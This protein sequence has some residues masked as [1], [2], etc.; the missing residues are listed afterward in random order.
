M[1]I[2]AFPRGRSFAFVA[3][4]LCL[5]T[6][7]AAAEDTT[8]V[9]ENATGIGIVEI[10]AIPSH[11]TDGPGRP[12]PQSIVPAGASARFTIA[13]GFCAY[14]LWFVFGDGHRFHDTMDFCEFGTYVVK[15]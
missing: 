9:I 8:F 15:R 5:F 12:L 13:D 14:E 3:F 2:L 4:A 7:A 6:S 1:A 11:H 10:Y